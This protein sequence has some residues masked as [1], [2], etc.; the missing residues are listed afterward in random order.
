MQQTGDRSTLPRFKDECKHDLKTANTDINYW[1][2]LALELA[3]YWKCSVKSAEE[4]WR[5]WREENCQQRKVRW[6]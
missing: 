6:V 5:Q 3:H 2:G 1:E 4:L